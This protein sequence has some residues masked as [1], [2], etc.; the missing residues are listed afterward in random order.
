MTN[1]IQDSIPRLKKYLKTTKLGSF[2]LELKKTR[3]QNK[4]S[5]IKGMRTVWNGLSKKSKLGFISHLQP[6]E[7][8][9]EKEFHIVGI[10]FVDRIMERF[11]GYGEV[12]PSYANVLEIGCGV[13]R[14]VKP[15]ACRFKDVTGVDISREM[16]K[17][18]R[19]YL[20]GLPNVTLL[21][22]D[23]TSLHRFEDESLDYCFSAGVFQHITHIEVILDY[24][25]EAV[26]VLKPGGL[27]L[28]QFVGSRIE[29]VG[30]GQTGAKIT[31]AELDAGLRNTPFVIREV[32]VDPADPVRNVVI[33]IQKPKSGE[34]VAASDRSFVKYPMTE[35]RWLSGVYDDVTTRTQM[36]ERLKKGADRLTFYDE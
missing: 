5:S 15:I 3:W 9:D 7:T 18:A 25:K 27:L 35:R 26:R 34:R 4:D 13:G 6:G 23:G 31:A 28:F 19:H 8:W 16:L 11:N 12:E 21:L 20:N 24:V 36:H 29:Q 32:S 33:V 17:T 14:F 22:N 1:F 10:R 30:H 2:Y